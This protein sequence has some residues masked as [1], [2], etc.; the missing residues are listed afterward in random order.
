MQLLSGIR[1]IGFTQFLLGPACTQYLA[2]MGADVIK[3]EDPV[4]GAWERRW[5]GGQTFINGVSGFYLLG[6]RNVR[7]VGINLKSPAGRQIAQDLI[8]TADVVVENFR[9]GVMDRLGLGYEQL[10][11]TFPRLVYA[12][13]TGY[14]SDGPYRMLP[15]QDLLLQAVSGLASLTGTAGDPPMPA[16]AAIVDQHAASLLALGI[17]GAVVARE[18]SGLGQRVEVTMVNAALD[19][20]QEPLVYFMNGGR[21]ERPRSH[22][23]SMFHEAPYGIYPASDGFLALSLS[24]LSSVA[25]ALGRPSALDPYLDPALAF[26][27]RDEIYHV[28][29][30]LIKP[31]AV[32]ET[33]EAMQEAGVWCSQV[34]DYE[35]VMQD[36]MVNGLD[37]W[38]VV[39]HPS[40]G[41]IRLVGHPIRYGS[42]EAVVERVPPSLGEHT[43]EVLRELGRGSDDIKRLA[44]DEIISTGSPLK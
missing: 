1:I 24:P 9:P 17:L 22:L 4:L 43:D 2:D 11:E 21:L 30:E 26:D 32:A 14:G 37:P 13:G 42:G 18:H 36:P 33:L 28:L 31:R 15:G 5:A 23:G 8:A 6:N 38:L 20:Q 19:L 34:N 25:D 35:S 12:S 40:A 10:R 7:S 39:D 29:A 41:R 27:K 44:D 3:V 16:G